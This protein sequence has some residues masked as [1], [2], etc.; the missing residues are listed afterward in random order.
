[1]LSARLAADLVKLSRVAYALEALLHSTIGDRA[2]KVWAID[3]KLSSLDQ[4]LSNAAP[5]A[6]VFTHPVGNQSII[7]RN[8]APVA[9]DVIEQ[10]VVDPAFFG[11]RDPRRQRASG[12]DL[13]C[14]I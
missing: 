14:A 13:A 12:C 1:M 5:Y 4:P 6:S 3:V 11:G 10:L 7:V 9:I 8:G 2:A